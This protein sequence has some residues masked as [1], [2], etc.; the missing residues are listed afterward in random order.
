MSDSNLD[1]VV[2]LEVTAPRKVGGIVEVP[3]R[4][5]HHDTLAEDDEVD[6]EALLR[7]SI[8]HNVLSDYDLEVV[9]EDNKE[10]SGGVP[11][12]APVETA[13]TVDN[14]DALLDQP[15]DTDV[16]GK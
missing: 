6:V 13:S 12:E 3:S 2:E 8:S 5:G 9:E 15:T 7:S 16:I 10:E 14:A 4:V 1:D 11:L